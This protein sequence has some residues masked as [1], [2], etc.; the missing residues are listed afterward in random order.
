MGNNLIKIEK[1]DL[2]LDI[3]LIPNGPSVPSYLL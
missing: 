2:F 1:Y 3:H